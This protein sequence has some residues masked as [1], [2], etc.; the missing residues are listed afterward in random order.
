MVFDTLLQVVLFLLLVT[1]VMVCVVC[2]TLT[3]RRVL[4]SIHI[5]SD[6]KHIHTVCY[7]G[8]TLTYV[9]MRIFG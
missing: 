5:H 4:D 2:L 8:A 7:K 3:E 1:F 9:S 6:S